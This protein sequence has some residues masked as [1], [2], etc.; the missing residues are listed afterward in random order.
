M[1]TLF[2]PLQIGDLTLSNRI[3]M[4]PLTRQRAEEIRVPN[5]L[6]AKYYAERATAGL[7][8]S[9]AT[10]VTPQGVGYAETPGIWS[11]EQVEGWKLVTNAVHAAGGKIFLQLWH[12]GR[13]SD[14]LFLNGELPVAPS[15]IAAQG[16]VSLVR[17]ERPYVTPRALGLDE[18]AGIVQAFRKGAENA[19]AAGFDGVEI[20][21]ANGYL[22]DQFLQ[23]ST[24]KR[25]DAYGGP[26]ENRAR[27]LLEITDACI[28]VWGAQR[29]GV[30]LAPRR[31][32][33][34]MGDSN[35]AA[36]FGYVARELGKRKIA[37]I[38][39]REALGEDRL[40]PQLK[41]EFGGPYIANE[42]FTK[43]TA[44]QVLD[45]GEADAVAWGQLFI[46]NPD[47]VRRFAM[48]A[49]LNK[50]DP[51]TFYARGETGYVDYPALEA[52]E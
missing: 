2:D 10:S 6:M 18:I 15:A 37:F 50:P 41:K 49:P 47:L 14:P 33:H 28:D 51:A 1:P 38:A 9:E 42:K 39:A 22:L 44:Q 46:A 26:I 17:P 19:K 12:V 40:G 35:P 48:N 34:D 30:H 8:I 3:I 36:T 5:A 13:I 21:G 43:E 24:N 25:T 52:V 7:I 45:A 16:H 11:P 29:V 27:L 4:A 23:D 20:H 31:D 32:A